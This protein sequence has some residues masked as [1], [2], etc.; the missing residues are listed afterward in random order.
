MVHYLSTIQ[1]VSSV[2]LMKIDTEEAE[3]EKKP[4][5]WG[6]FLAEV[7]DIMSPEPKISGL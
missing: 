4:H 6:F 7:C 1:L 3:N 5:F 2:L